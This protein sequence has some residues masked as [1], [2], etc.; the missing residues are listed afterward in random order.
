MKLPQLR[1]AAHQAL[2]PLLGKPGNINGPQTWRH[3]TPVGDVVLVTLVDLSGASRQLEYEHQVETQDG[4]PLG[5]GISLQS[6]LGFSSMTQWDLL[7]PDHVEDAVHQM[8]GLCRHFLQVL[9]RLAA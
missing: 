6:W 2:D 4:R 3:R 8:L 9:P 1:G 7:Q 5:R